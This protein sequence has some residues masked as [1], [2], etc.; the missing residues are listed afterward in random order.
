METDK[1]AGE[2]TK[3]P[4]IARPKTYDI[5][6]KPCLETLKCSGSSTIHLS[7]L[8]ETSF[9]KLH[10]NELDIKSVSAILQNG[11]E[12]NNLPTQVD[13]KWAYLTVNFPSVLEPQDMKL[14][15]EFVG[16]L[17]DKMQGF[18]YST[19]K[20]A[21]GSEKVM[22]STQFESTHARTCFPCWDEPIYK[23]TFNIT[24]E[25][26]SKLTALSNMK[27]IE[28]TPGSNGTKIVR[29]QE[30][31]KMSTYLVA[32]AVGD[33]EYIETTSDGGIVVRVYTVPGKKEEGRYALE[34]AAKCL[35]W[36]S[37]WFDIPCALPKCDLIAI[38]DFKMG[39]MENW[40]LVTYREVCLLVDPKKTS[41][42]GKTHVAMVI[43]HELAHFWFG[44]LATMKWWTD[45]WLKE[46]FASIMEYVFLGHNCPEFKIWNHFVVYE[47]SRAF[48]LDGLRNSHPIEVEIN[49]PNELD[50]IYDFITYSKSNSLNRMLCNYISEKVFQRGLRIY[51][52]KFSYSNAETIDLWNAFSEASGENIDKLMSSW[53]KQM[54]YP[55]VTVLEQKIEGNKRILKLKQHR[56]LSDGGKD[57]LESIWQIPIEISTASG[58]LNKIFMTKSEEEFVLDEVAEND[59]IKLNAGTSGF[60]R[61]KYTTEMFNS[62][63]SAV[64]SKQLPILDRFGMANDLHGLFTSGE[65]TAVEFLEFFKAFSNE[66]EYIV[67]K[68]IDQ[69]LGTISNIINHS[70]DVKLQ[71][72]YK[73]LVIS[74]LQKISKSLGLNPVPNEDTQIGLLREL[75]QSRLSKCNDLETVQHAIKQFENHVE[76]GVELTPDLRRVYFGVAARQNTKE[77]IEKIQKIFKTVGSSEV[78]ED[79]ILAM[80]QVS[81]PELLKEI[82]NYGINENNI[83]PQ[84]TSYLFIASQGSKVGQDFT[85][86]YFKDNFDLLF[87]IF[88][89][90]NSAIF[91][92]CFKYSVESSCD[93]AKADE[94]WEFFQQKLDPY[95]WH[96]IERPIAQV[97]E[98]ISNNS[99]CYNKNIDELRK[100]L[101]AV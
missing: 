100:Y 68:A 10:A 6:L 76:T 83:R 87:R 18:S 63:L 89:S 80:G 28:E 36:Y 72:S 54:G 12:L 95:S 74:V 55:L 44:N 91:Q 47:L 67:W 11:K 65:I 60:Y 53:T 96:I 52:K 1:K 88:G 59:W 93:K 2:F 27:V 82:Y 46:G 24:L 19:F 43:A 70:N 42:Q 99:E 5:R 50:E 14:K 40:G 79:C 23:A 13:N 9:L 20:G 4:E 62:L 38:P 85:W 17:N 39:A 35:D 22:A 94:V 75:I 21:D 71:N 66:N 97:M 61:V 81:T 29:Y 49:N 64:K 101:S 31:P 90:V 41:T 7:I 8:Q 77:N 98:K 26:D 73:Q 51:L 86:Q 78:V 32:F 33:F 30:T 58:G 57:P 56:F 92:R 45:L 69:G 34:L 48:E 84:D 3:L 25:V 15:F 16:E 37:E